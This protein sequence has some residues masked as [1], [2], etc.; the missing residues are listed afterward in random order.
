MLKLLLVSWIGAMTAR[1]TTA[2]WLSLGASTAPLP[3]VSPVR[4]AE[5]FQIE[6]TPSKPT[7]SRPSSPAS[8]RES[9]DEDGRSLNKRSSAAVASLRFEGGGNAPTMK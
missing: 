5:T 4:N 6:P 3:Y 7:D 8:P 1:A 2:S 9:C